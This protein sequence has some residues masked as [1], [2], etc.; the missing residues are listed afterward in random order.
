[1]RVS[2]C[3]HAVHKYSVNEKRLLNVCEIV[4]FGVMGE[5]VSWLLLCIE[6]SINA[7]VGCLHIQDVIYGFESTFL[8]FIGLCRPGT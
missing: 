2:R 4:R 3:F 8:T 5:K 7:Y 1:M 6:I